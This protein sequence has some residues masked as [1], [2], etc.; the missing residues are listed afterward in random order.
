MK[1]SVVIPVYNEEE[2]IEPCLT[3][4]MQQI[5]PPDEIIVVDNNCTDDTVQIA[6]QFN[7]KIVKEEEQGMAFSRTKGFN[8]AR[9][10]IIARCDADAI[11]PPNWTQRIKL[12]F[13][14]RRRIDGLIGL[15]TFYD[16]PLRNIKLMN[17][18]AIFLVKEIAGHYPLFGT[19]MAISKTVWDSIK[20]EVCLNNDDFHEDIDL[21]IHI[22]NKGGIIVFDP[23]FLAQ[24]SAR[25]LK[26]N[27]YEFFIDYPSRIITTINGHS[28]AT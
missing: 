22:H 24:F 8:C 4:L 16:F 19:S 20:N 2:Y 17:K 7:V 11:L 26:K 12:N 9:Y 6:K 23:K 10:D 28:S 25:R 18:A 21:S 5:E 3:S 14:K 27:P 1:I 15:N 13:E